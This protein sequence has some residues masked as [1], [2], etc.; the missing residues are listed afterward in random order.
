MS[1]LFGFETFPGFDSFLRASW[2]ISK[3]WLDGMSEGVVGMRELSAWPRVF[4]D[5]LFF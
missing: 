5:K 3:V 4:V 1:F 2:Y